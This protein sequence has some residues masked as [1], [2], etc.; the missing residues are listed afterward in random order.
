MSSNQAEEPLL[1]L[2]HGCMFHMSQ[3]KVRVNWFGAYMYCAS[4]DDCWF[5]VIF[6]I[7]CTGRELIRCNMLPQLVDSKSL[8]TQCT[9]NLYQ[10]C[11]SIFRTC[12]SK[13]RRRDLLGSTIARGRKARYLKVIETPSVCNPCH[14]VNSGFVWMLL[15]LPMIPPARM[16]E[17]L[18]LLESEVEHLGSPSAQAFGHDVLAY[19]R[20]QNLFRLLFSVTIM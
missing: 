11:I 12:G 2:V 18:Q 13:S 5:K 3:V 9:N 6:H 20:F 4:L 16:N 14:F 8:S 7:N 19:I 15:A 1:H 10:K 17:Y